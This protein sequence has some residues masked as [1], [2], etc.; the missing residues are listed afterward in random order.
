MVNEFEHISEL[1]TIDDCDHPGQVVV[2]LKFHDG[3]VVNI[4]LADMA[5]AASTKLPTAASSSSPHMGRI[6]QDIRQ[7]LAKA[8]AEL[9]TIRLRN[10]RTYHELGETAQFGRRAIRGDVCVV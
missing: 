8:T 9:S 1:Q 6:Y 5:A 7:H 2:R 3:R 4:A 10:A